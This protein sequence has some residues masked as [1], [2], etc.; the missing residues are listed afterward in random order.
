MQKDGEYLMGFY[1]NA[2]EQVREA[3]RTADE[4]VRLAEVTSLTTDKRAKVTFYGETAESGKTYTYI[5][6]YVPKVGDKVLLIKQGNTYV[7]IG[8]AVATAVA[9]KYAEVNHNHDGV[10]AA[11]G[12]TH[13]Q[14]S[15]KQHTHSGYASS[16][17]KHSILKNTAVSPTYQLELKDSGIL[18][19]NSSNIALGSS[20]MQF[21]EVRAKNVYINGTAVSTSDRRKKKS[22]KN[23]SAKYIEFF[24]RLRPVTF[25]YKDGTSGRI[26]SG[27]IAQEVEKALSDS[28]IR[29]D[30]FGGLVIQENGEYGLRYEEFI[31]IQT[32]IIQE[33]IGRVEQ[34]ERSLYDK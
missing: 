14:Y 13:A 2:E 29:A 34:L 22:I 33:L 20:G 24:K 28:D 32:K 9:V 15:L 1:Q 30:E 8:A 18:M 27:F 5:D 19:P 10:Y 6:G 12:H 4:L 26:H 11:K 23:I 16:D 25:K 31:A 21:K 3:Q 7:I 17:H